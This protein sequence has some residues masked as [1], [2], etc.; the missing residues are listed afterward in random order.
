MRIV[1][2]GGAG[3]IGSHVTDR[4]IKNGHEVTVID[5]LSTGK[6]EHVNP[7]AEFVA[8]DILKE[9]VSREIRDNDAVFHMAADPDVRSSARSPTISFNSNVIMTFKLMEICRKAKI[10][11]VVFASTS[12]V[13]GEADTIPQRVPSQVTPLEAVGGDKM[14]E[15][16]VWCLPNLKPCPSNPAEHIQVFTAQG[17]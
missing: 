3:F 6:K 5:N 4:L 17:H 10:K 7:E 8:K 15:N 2:T 1:V 11:H 12:T 13:Y 14:V 16:C 9:N